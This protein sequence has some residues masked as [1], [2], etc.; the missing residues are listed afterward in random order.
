MSHGRILIALSN[1]T[2]ASEC[3]YEVSPEMFGLLSR[4]SGE[5]LSRAMPRQTPDGM[6]HE[7]VSYAGALVELAKA[8]GVAERD[9][10]IREVT[11]PTFRFDTG[12]GGSDDEPADDGDGRNAHGFGEGSDGDIPA[13]GG[14]PPLSQEEIRQIRRESDFIDSQQEFE[15]GR[16]RLV[17]IVRHG[18]R[19]LAI[20]PTFGTASLPLH[21]RIWEQP[22]EVRRVQRKVHVNTVR[23][24][25]ADATGDA[26]PQLGH[27]PGRLHGRRHRRHR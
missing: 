4:M 19:L 27:R 14:R 6:G 3:L 8:R 11:V 25:P 22:Y 10:S 23:W 16:T 7:S 20:A 15:N 12:W 1:E 2:T 18:D 13:D 5:E 9:I 17:S 24:E 26:T 21:G